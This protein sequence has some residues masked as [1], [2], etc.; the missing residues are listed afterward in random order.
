M[1]HEEVRKYSKCII[2]Y[3]NVNM[4]KIFNSVSLYKKQYY[5]RQMVRIQI[6]NAHTRINTTG[7]NT[8]YHTSCGVWVAHS[9]A[10]NINH[11]QSRIDTLTFYFTSLEFVREQVSA[12]M[13]FGRHVHRVLSPA[14][15]VRGNLVCYVFTRWRISA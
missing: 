7:L 5:F 3:A 9:L 14:V 15:Y 13:S 6:N 8:G 12:M 4:F 2:C 10:S 1:V 11:M